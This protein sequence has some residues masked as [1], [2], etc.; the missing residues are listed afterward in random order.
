[1]NIG[2]NNTVVATL[3]DKFLAVLCKR[4]MLVSIFLISGIKLQGYIAAFDKYVIIL[5]SDTEQLV[6]KHAI[7]TVM[8]DGVVLPFM[9]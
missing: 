4:K 7:S 2:L 5:K 6:F 3:Q 1:M 9:D 8:P